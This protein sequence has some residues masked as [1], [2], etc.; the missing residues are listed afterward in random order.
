MR[1]KYVRWVSTP[2]IFCLHFTMIICYEQDAILMDLFSTCIIS[3]L[4]KK[5]LDH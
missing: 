4:K 5:N 2:F 1:E 3:T